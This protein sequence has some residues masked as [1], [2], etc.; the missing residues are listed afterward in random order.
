MGAPVD[1][2]SRRRLPADA[3]CSAKDTTH[4]ALMTLYRELFSQQIETTSTER[5]LRDWQWH[6]RQAG[7]EATPM[8]FSRFV[9]N[10]GQPRGESDD[11]RTQGSPARQARP[12]HRGRQPPSRP[13]PA[14]R[15]S[16]RN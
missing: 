16:E 9:Q 2:G 13:R 11:P 15:R 14:D 12:R 10:G 1:W 6:W 4:D 5:V 3:L 7:W 8:A